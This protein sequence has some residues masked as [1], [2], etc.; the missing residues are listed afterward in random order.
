LVL[1]CVPAGLRAQA[2]APTP[3]GPGSI[4]GLVVDDGGRPVAAATVV[5]RREAD[6]VAVA[7][8]VTS[9]SG[10]F[11]VTGLALGRYA[12][13][14]AH[15]GY[16]PQTRTGITLTQAAP[17]ADLGVVRLAVAAVA[18]EG[19]EVSAEQAAVVLAPDRNIYQTKDM[20]AASAGT[21]VDVL[22]NVPEVDVDVNGKVSLRGN[23]SV[24]I[25]INGR[26]SPLKGDALTNFLQQFPASRIERV[27]VIPNPSAKFDPEG[28]VGIVNIVLKNNA[29]LGLSGSLTARGGNAGGG[30]NGRLAYQRGALTLFA[31]GGSSASRSRQSG[32]DFRQNLLA[33]PVTSLDQSSRRNGDSRFYSGDLSAE[34]RLSK[35]ATLYS[36]FN[37]F[38]SEGDMDVLTSYALL[39][40][41]QV[42]LEQY[43][44]RGPSGYT[45]D[46][47]DAS[48][49]FRRVVKPQQDEL[50]IEVRANR[51]GEGTDDRM[52]KAPSAADTD[53]PEGEVTLGDVDTRTREVSLQADYTHPLGASLRLDAGYKGAL[54]RSTGDS[55]LEVFAPAGAVAP[56]QDAR[57]AFTHDERF[58]SAY[59]LLQRGF[60]KLGVQAG[61]RAE[62]AATTF[63]LRRTGEAFDNDYTSV[64]PSVNLS[65][66]LAPGRQARLAY[67]KRIERPTSFYLNPDVPSTDPLNRMAGNPYLK[68][69]YTHSV[70]L[71]LSWTLA[72]GTLRLSPY[73]RRTVDNWDWVKLVDSAGVSTM[74]FR[75]LASLEA[76]GA[77]ITGSLRPGGRLSGFGSLAV[78]RQV[79]DASNISTQ[80]SGSALHWSAT[81]TPMFKATSSLDLQGM[82]RYSPAQDLP[83]GKISAWVMSSIGAKQ[84]I[85]GNRAWVNLYLN[86]PFGL[87]RFEFTTRD[88]T[89]VQTSRST[90][91]SR[92]VSLSFTYSFGRAPQPT[93]RRQPTEQPEQPQ[94]A[95][96]IH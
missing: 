70:T 40:P 94:P 87:M 1:A 50:T 61:V 39:D 63:E 35:E 46:V 92:T 12:V 27:E 4:L 66:D 31:G 81:L 15:L 41:Q 75:N 8:A 21:A 26:P 51:N 85:S 56:A 20:P 11:R 71:D 58:H 54:R 43:V 79:R 16:A 30:G 74:T 5:V 69:K 68:P 60:G 82:L 88:A 67:S 36:A 93:A 64:F 23:G 29:D 78:Y 25:H 48:L 24:A 38:R 72:A 55:R 34:L 86:D 57:S 53:A 7:D 52:T 28:M 9:A 84:R 59:L 22:R 49:G 91:M 47:L 96:P 83:Q 89:H 95:V 77:T 42:A 3:A 32:H 33:S 37:G 13:R 14:I 2:A 80:F 65:Y 62:R 90:F 76:Y 6:S 10:R 44:R 17:S 18:V 73:W 45:Y 19:I